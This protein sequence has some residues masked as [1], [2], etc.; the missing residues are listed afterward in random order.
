MNDFPT[1]QEPAAEKAARELAELHSQADDARALL[2][3]LRQEL[4]EAERCLATN[5]A[6]QLLETNE[7]LVLS[8]LRAQADAVTTVLA[9]EEVSQSAEVQAETELRAR[10]ALARLNSSLEDR[11]SARTRDLE[12]ARDEA[13]AGVC[14]KEQFLSNMSHEIRTPMNG[15][16]GALELVSQTDL[17][18]RQAEFIRV[19]TA[20]GEALL[21]IL[22]EVLDF[23]KIGAN[24]F[25]LAAEPIDVNAIARSVTTMFSASAQRKSIGLHLVADSALSGL[26]LGDAL[27]LRQVLMNLVGNAMKFT[28]QGQV[29][30][31]TRRIGGNENN[32]VAFEV[33]DTG[34]GIEASQHARIFE[35][36]VQADDP[37]NQRGG[38]TGLGLAISRQLVR[39]MGGELSVASVLGE[40]ATFRFELNLERAPDQPSPPAAESQAA[41]RREPLN[42]R[43]LLVEDN[44]VN[45]LVGSAM[46]QSLGFEV[47]LAEHGEEALGALADAAVQAVLMDCQMPVMDGYEATRRI[48]EFERLG[49]R[50]R[51]PVI[52]LTANAFSG[53]VERCLAAGMDAHLAKPY[54]IEQLRAVIV[55]WLPSGMASV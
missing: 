24:R 42:G 5:H 41:V 32:R 38:G 11:V 50:P 9:M 53:D 14:A 36:F 44:S 3:R 10:E 52:A 49:S 29:V 12:N 28:L 55:P 1:R 45:R 30:V 16:L 6:T 47:L 46:L 34:M 43:V 39:A 19:A 27:R 22:N 25:Q 13:L 7:Q 21:G 37:L 2:L 26:R 15:M 51:T 54:T 31:K 40:G 35:A 8:T 20:S 18:P 48:R 17:T 4:T 23:A 33:S